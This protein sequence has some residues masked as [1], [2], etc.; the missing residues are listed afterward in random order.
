MR[1]LIPVFLLCALLL[2]A[3]AGL[4]GDG[5]SASDRTR[6]VFDGAAVEIQGGGARDEGSAVV[7]SAA[8]TYELSG[9]SSEKTLVVD[10]GDDA[11][12]VTLILNNVE[13]FSLLDPAIHVK[14][15]K[16]FR[17]Q[18]AEGSKNRLVQGE[19]AM[20]ESIDPN[21]S[22]AALYSEDDMD[23]E[24]EGALEVCGYIN[25]GIGCKNDLDINS[26]TLTV[27]AANNGVKGNDSV[28]LKGGT[29][30]VTAYGDGIKSS[31]L[32]K[33]G[34]GFV[35]ISGG[36][37]T[38]EAWGDG[39]QAAA[40]LRILGGDVSVT[41]RGDG[42]A[43]SSKAL[44]AERSVLLSGGT[45]KLSSREDGLRAAE[46]SVSIS[47]GALEILALGDGIQAGEKDSG[48][49]DLLLSG[50]TV[51]VFAGKRAVKAQGDFTVTGGSLTA[52]SGS[53]K[54]AGP[55]GELPWLLF[56]LNGS[57]GDSL[58]IDGLLELEAPLAYGRLLLIREGLTVGESLTLSN[59]SASVSAPVR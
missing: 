15:A 53:D 20:L 5:R 27:V 29:L 35:E 8:G 28:Q 37:V 21:A 38:V 10:T 13:I 7:I 3:C 36:T 51:S 41:A 19:E 18:L 6:I 12:D 22:G 59:G 33:E 44:K 58:R 4:G 9:K 50:G 45:V 32:D 2:T 17:L 1:K 26:G 56:V 24:G 23:I 49:G 46:G 47:G 55:V 30:S 40:E 43:Q 31:T 34:K 52:L 16:H 11:M 42:T 57:A 39:V 48:L 25:N 54:Q 14:Q